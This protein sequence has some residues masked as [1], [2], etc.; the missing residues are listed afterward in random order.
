ML[1]AYIWDIAKRFDEKGALS[2]KST[3][4]FL[5]KFMNAYAD[6]VGRACNTSLS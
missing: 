1:E 5:Q 4:E 2:D 3:Q 6:W